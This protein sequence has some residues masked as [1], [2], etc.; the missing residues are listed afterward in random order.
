[1]LPPERIE[2][3]LEERI[4][5]FCSTLEHIESIEKAR[6]GES[7]AGAEFVAGFGAAISQAAADY[8]REHGPSLVEGSQQ[9]R[10]APN[11]GAV[12]RPSGLENRA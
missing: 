3:L 5:D 8:L 11:R 6:A 1:L 2:Q 9:Q 10:S 7:H 12:S 4:R